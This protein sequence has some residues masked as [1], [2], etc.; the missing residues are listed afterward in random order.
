M[1]G[2]CTLS[3]VALEAGTADLAA[4]ETFEAHSSLGNVINITYHF[5][6]GLVAKDTGLF[7]VQGTSSV[8]MRLPIFG[9]KKVFIIQVVRT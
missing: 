2:S 1:V 7:G 3:K 4:E 5:L 8:G 9:R 6:S